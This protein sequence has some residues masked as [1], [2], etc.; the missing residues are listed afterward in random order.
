V[1]AFANGIGSLFGSHLDLR[2]IL[3]RNPKVRNSMNYRRLRHL[4]LHSIAADLRLGRILFRNSF[5]LLDASP[6]KH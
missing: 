3:R 4:P 6:M 2:R 5:P 1:F